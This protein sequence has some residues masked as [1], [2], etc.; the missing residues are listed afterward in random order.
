LQA[1]ILDETFCERKTGINSEWVNKNGAGF[2]PAPLS[3]VP[4]ALCFTRRNT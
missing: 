2:W 4:P 3:L 1:Q